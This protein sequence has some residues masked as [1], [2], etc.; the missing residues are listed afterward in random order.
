MSTR[1]NGRNYKGNWSPGQMGI[2]GHLLDKRELL[3]PM[4]IG[5]SGLLGQW[6]LGK[7]GTRK[8]EHQGKQVGYLRQM[9]TL[10]YNGHLGTD[11]HWGK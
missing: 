5:A 7:I 1:K 3:R 11:G 9:S 10:E 8:N 6:A 4:G 2:W